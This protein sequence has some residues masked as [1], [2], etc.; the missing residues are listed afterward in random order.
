LGKRELYAISGHWSLYREDMFPPMNTVAEQMLLR[1]S[2]YPHHALIYRSRQHGHRDLPLHLAEL[3]AQ[4]RAEASGALGGLT[5]LW[6]MQFND[7]HIFGRPDQVATEVGAVLDL[8]ARAYDVLGISAHR[9]RL[10]LRG[11]SDKYVDDPAM[12]DLAEH[13]L[14]EVLD[15]RGLAYDA[16]SGE[17]AFYGPKIDV[18]ALDQAGRESTLST[19]QVDFYQS[20]QFDLNYRSADQSLQPPRHGQLGILGILERLVTHQTV[21]RAGRSPP[22]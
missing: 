7:A 10:S 9:Y 12:W 4:F 14:A 8:I 22:G 3:G 19:V 5:R 11:H 15:Q 2:L 1:L 13:A 20:A 18:Q 17:G 16:A 21:V 6:A